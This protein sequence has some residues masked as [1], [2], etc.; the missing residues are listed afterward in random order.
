MKK[1]SHK[2]LKEQAAKAFAESVKIIKARNERIRNNPNVDFSVDEKVYSSELEALLEKD[3]R[4]YQ[5]E[6]LLVEEALDVLGNINELSL[7]GLG[8]REVSGKDET[9]EVTG[10]GIRYGGIHIP[11][12][13][14]YWD[15]IPGPNDKEGLQ[16]YLDNGIPEKEAKL[17]FYKCECRLDFKEIA[18]RLNVKKEKLPYMWGKVLKKWNITE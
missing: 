1:K 7:M 18:Q 15:A 17:I 5:R 2:S 3:T 14:E 6:T 8:P 11:T 4:S 9:G 16:K 13:E 12:L 10:S